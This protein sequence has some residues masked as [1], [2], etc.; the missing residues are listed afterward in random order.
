MWYSHTGHR[1]QYTTVCA[2]CVLRNESYRHTLTTCNTVFPLQHWFH[3]RAPLLLSYLHRLFCWMLTLAVCKATS[4][5]VTGW[6][7]R[8]SNPGGRRDFLHPS[9]TPWGPPS[10]LYN[11]YRAIPACKAA[12]AWGW[13]PTTSSA[14]VKGRVVLHLYP[15]SGH[16]W[17]VIGWT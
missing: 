15:P 10:H 11:G 2:L 3:E 7:V 14:E 8:G 1:W 12:G 5:L 13:S 17:H 6:M 4:G 9:R 16:S